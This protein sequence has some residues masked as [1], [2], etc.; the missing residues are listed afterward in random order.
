MPQN[1]Y[2]QS[3]QSRMQPFNFIKLGAGSPPTS[4]PLPTAPPNTGTAGA[5]TGGVSAAG[6]TLLNYYLGQQNQANQLAQINAMKTVSSSSP[7]PWASGSMLAG[8]SAA[9]AG[10]AGASA[11]DVDSEY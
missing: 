8:A 6:G 5:I 11:A 9:G 1:D 2:L 7:N 3:L 10:S 4:Q